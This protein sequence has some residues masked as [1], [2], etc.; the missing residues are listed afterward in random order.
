MLGTKNVVFERHVGTWKFT[1][2]WGF[3]EPANAGFK[4]RNTDIGLQGPGQK[5]QDVCLA[6]VVGTIAEVWPSA[7]FQNA[8]AYLCVPLRNI[9]WV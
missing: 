7:F 4:D 9:L 8:L 2:L 5:E 6:P 3:S 1:L